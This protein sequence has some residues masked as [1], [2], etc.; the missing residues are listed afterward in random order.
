M[1]EFDRLITRVVYAS[2]ATI[3]PPV[4]SEMERIRDSALRHNVPLQINTALLYQCGWFLQWKEGPAAEIFSL[5]K[6][7]GRDQ[8]HRDLRVLHS[9]EG[10]RL[11]DGPWSMAIVQAGD[12]HEAMGERVAEQERR[13]RAGIS[14]GPPAVWRRLS[15]PLQGHADAAD[16]AAEAYQRVLVCSAAGNGSFELLGWLARSMSL[17]LVHRRFAGETGLDVGTNLLDVFDPDAKRV[18]RVVAMARKGL[19]LAL[20]RALLPDY[21]HIVLLL[22][23]SPERDLPLI[24][25]VADVCAGLPSGPVV[26]G[27]WSDHAAHREPEGY[28][29]SFGLDYREVIADVLTPQSLWLALRPVLLEWGRAANS[30]T[31][32]T[33]SGHLSFRLKR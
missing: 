26:V 15:T 25:R 17:D 12:T 23:G 2:E 5:M 11:L 31:A 9:S 1:Q 10:P 24:E 7:L 20:T 32:P 19:S 8:R 29:R 16:A 14:T 27:V 18:I 22:S 4:Y 21:S 28:A 30:S 6:R 3:A 33:E 13:M